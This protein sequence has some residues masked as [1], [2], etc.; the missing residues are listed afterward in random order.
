MMSQRRGSERGCIGRREPVHASE[1]KPLDADRG[2]TNRLQYKSGVERE[3]DAKREERLSQ[4]D[5][6]LS[7]AHFYALG[8]GGIP[9]AV[10]AL[11]CGY[12]DH[13][14]RFISS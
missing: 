3:P 8:K 13:P 2:L 10:S 9:G 12:S 6:R 1:A 5:N 11:R 4:G 7:R 14:T